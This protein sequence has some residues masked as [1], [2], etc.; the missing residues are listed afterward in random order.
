MA[1]FYTRFGKTAADLT[2]QLNPKDTPYIAA[3][4]AEVL[5]DG[6]VFSVP[7]DTV[8]GLVADAQNNEALTRLYDIK[9]RD[10]K[11]PVAICLAQISQIYEWAQVSVP[12]EVL[13]EF[14]PGPVTLVFKR[15]PALNPSLN[16]DTDL[17]G[18]RIPRSEFMN[19]LAQAHGG[20]IALTSANL[21]SAPSTVSCTEFESLWPEL[22]L[23]I[24][25]GTLS[26]G[27][28]G[29]LDR[30]G[31]TVIDLARKGFFRII[32]HGTACETTIQTLKNKYS[33]QEWF[34][35]ES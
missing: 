34:E 18:I 12:E 5:K 9:G 1:S 8:Y 30:K 28:G 33:L 26:S 23:V 4:T 22:D 24:D 35:F 29:D 11:K 10:Y 19:N 13:K 15:R 14:L 27:E 2:I 7:T 3:I 6:G 17:I 25:G 21:A 32:R 16:P 31:S 20:P